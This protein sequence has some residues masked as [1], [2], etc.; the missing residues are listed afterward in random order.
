MNYLQLCQMAAR[1]TGS[2]QGTQPGSVESQTGLLARLVAHVSEAWTQIQNDRSDWK[3]MRRELSSTLAVTVAGTYRYAPSSFGITSHSNWIGDSLDSGGFIVR[4]YSIYLQSTGV[5]NESEL[6][7][8]S[9]ETFRR[10]YMFGTQTQNRPIEWSESP[11]GEFCLGPHPNDIYVINGEYQKGPQTFLANVDV[12]EMPERFHAFIA[13]RGAE[14]FAEHHEIPADRL[15]TIRS[16][17]SKYRNDI[18]RDQLPSPSI[19]APPIA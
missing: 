13:W 1:E 3:W 9:W 14:L 12:P 15:S 16:N 18:E 4:R 17:V 7:Q 8:I 11:Q 2:F 6:Q 5:S 10:R 19:E